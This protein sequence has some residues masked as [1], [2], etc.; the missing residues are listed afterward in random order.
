MMK[1]SDEMKWNSALCRQIPSSMD[2]TN[3]KNFL[4]LIC[5][6]GGGIKCQ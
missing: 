2:K 4:L 5:L 3:A 1:R 6:L